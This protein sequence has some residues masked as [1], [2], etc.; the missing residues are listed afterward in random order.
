[1]FR[2]GKKSSKK[3]DSEN[4]SPDCNQDE[5]LL[6]L[7]SDFSFHPPDAAERKAYW[8]A[9]SNQVDAPTEERF[10][11]MFIREVVGGLPSKTTSAF[12]AKAREYT[13][14]PDAVEFQIPRR[15]ERADNPPEGYF[16]CYDAVLVRCRLWF[17]IPEIIVCVLDRFQVSFSQLNP[18]SFE[19]LIGLVI[20]CYEHGLSLITDHFE[21]LV[22]VQFVREL[23][24]W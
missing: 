24:C 18:T 8:K 6:V 20:L 4:P 5:E 23:R 2:S 13:R 15:G 12:L 3:K 11:V 22:R 9:C 21:A 10:P 1:M 14:V 7:K 19:I 16:T 17:P